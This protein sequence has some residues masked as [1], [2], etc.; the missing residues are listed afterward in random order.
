MTGKSDPA[1]AAIDNA[2]AFMDAMLQSDWLELH[3]ATDDFELF[4]AREG[5]GPNPMF[6]GAELD[7][8]PAPAAAAKASAITAPHVATLVWAAQP[9]TNVAAGEALARISVLDE[10]TDI[11]AARGGRVVAVDAAPGELVEFGM[12]ILQIVEA[13]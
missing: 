3:V 9:G 6:A 8:V 7:E 12:T 1:A 11:T 4:I 2:R 5:G 13:A 10:E